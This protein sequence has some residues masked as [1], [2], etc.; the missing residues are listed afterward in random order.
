ME[1]KYFIKGQKK[2][3]EKLLEWKSIS[4]CYEKRIF[5]NK[6]ES[7]T[8]IK[9]V[10]NEEK[11]SICVYELSPFVSYNSEFISSKIIGYISFKNESKKLYFS[12]AYRVIEHALKSKPLLKR[13][14]LDWSKGHLLFERKNKNVIQNFIL[15]KISSKKEYLKLTYKGLVPKSNKIPYKLI[16]T[17]KLNYYEL[18]PYIKVAENVENLFKNIKKL[19]LDFISDLRSQAFWLQKKINFNWSEKRMKQVH[20]EW[21]K[22]I[23]EIKV[24]DMEEKRVSYSSMIEISFGK[25][26]TSNKDLYIEGSEMDHCVFSNGYW[27]RVENK[28]GL[29]ISYS[30]KG[31][32]GT[33]L[34]EK[35]KNK[36]HIN[37]FYGYR[38]HTKN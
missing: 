9:F 5:A 25:I 29:I 10:D 16:N 36:P 6:Y 12:N 27:T 20:S 17:S 2:N 32:R 38:L 19:D 22:I 37:Q 14:N 21:S 23:S 13:L 24:K 15:G 3:L 34:I 30:N 35:R 4:D 8:I 28:T 11:K 31:K 26:I 7:T 33:V 1:R 18:K